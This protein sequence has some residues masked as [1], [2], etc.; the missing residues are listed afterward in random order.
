MPT[1]G[2]SGSARDNNTPMARVTGGGT[3]AAIWRDF[4]ASALTRIKTSAIPTGPV[5][6]MDEAASAA[7]DELL[8]SSPAANDNAVP[9]MVTMEPIPNP[10]DQQP[11]PTNADDIFSEAQRRNQ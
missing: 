9:P 8:N 6:E 10:E 11:A 2:T 3:P 7:V 5:S 4:M 1:E